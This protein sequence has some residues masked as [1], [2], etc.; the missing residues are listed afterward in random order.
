MKIIYCIG[1]FIVRLQVPDRR[2][3]NGSKWHCLLLSKWLSLLIYLV[4]TTIHSFYN[5]N[6]M[7]IINLRYISFVLLFTE[8]NLGYFTVSFKM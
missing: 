6:I 2:G 7:Y 1:M 8:H 3:L 4:S 5:S